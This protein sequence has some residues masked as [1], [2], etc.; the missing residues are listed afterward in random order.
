MRNCIILFVFIGIALMAP[1]QSKQIYFLVDAVTDTTMDQTG[2]AAR[3]YFYSYPIH[4]ANQVNEK[5]VI[6]KFK[7]FLK[8]KHGVTK[9]SSCV[10][11][12]NDNYEDVKALRDRSI[13]KY[14]TRG[15]QILEVTGIY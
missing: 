2:K 15:F 13:D 7:E 8:T 1:A 5:I 14:R 11:R 9:F 12:R 4:H 6:D 3:I 10:L